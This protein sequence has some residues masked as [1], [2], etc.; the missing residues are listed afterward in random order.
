MSATSLIIIYSVDGVD[1]VA[2]Y[3]PADQVP[4][5]IVQLFPRFR[6][7]YADYFDAFSKWFNK[8]V[9]KNENI[10]SGES[11]CKAVDGPVRVLFYPTYTR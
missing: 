9:K 10:I 8:D 6:D 2:Y 7:G 3:V 5:E 11:D 1:Q 4:D